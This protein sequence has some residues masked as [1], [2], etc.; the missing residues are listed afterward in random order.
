MRHPYSHYINTYSRPEKCSSY[1]VLVEAK[2]IN[3]PHFESCRLV[4]FL[5]DP[6][7]FASIKSARIAEQ[8]VIAARAYIGLV[9]K[10]VLCSSY[11]CKPE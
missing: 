7:L 10:R 5:Q 8:A 2:I 11:V 3:L 4:V 6:L 9:E 1:D